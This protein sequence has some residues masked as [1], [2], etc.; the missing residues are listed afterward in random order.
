MRESVRGIE[1]GLGIFLLGR[2]PIENVTSPG[3]CF[4]GPTVKQP[5][6]GSS[7]RR[8]DRFGN[9]GTQASAGVSVR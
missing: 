7:V 6:A 2:F 1:A 8:Q 5:S 4:A 9:T 3:G